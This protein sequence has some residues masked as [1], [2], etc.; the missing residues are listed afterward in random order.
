MRVIVLAMLALVWLAGAVRAGGLDE[1]RNG[2]AAFREGRY[3][4]AVELFTTAIVSGELDVEALAIAYN[5]R[6]VA[7]DQLGDYDRAV[8]DYQ[9]ALSLKPDDAMSRRNLRVVLVRRGVALANTGEYQRALTDLSKAIELGPDKAIA[10][11]RR[12]QVR[13][14][15]GDLEGAAADLAEARKLAPGDE[16]IA[17]AEERLAKLGEAAREA[18]VQLTTHSAP[19]PA[20]AGPAPVAEKPPAAAARP[21]VPATDGEQ[22]AAAEPPAASAAGTE[23][24]NAARKAGV[25]PAT[26]AAE[27]GRPYR[28]LADVNV[29]SGPGNRY[30]ARRIARKGTVVRVVGEKLGWK[31][32]IFEDG[33]R[34]FIYRKWLEPLDDAG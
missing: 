21:A 24:E 2:N 1:I 11:L 16:E 20:A 18:A 12:A 27:E 3:E 4:Q 31:E 34:G 23:T 5:N 8:A 29:R 25:E 10:W 33:G 14:E 15:S 30:A 13:M 17:R 6:G 32:V 7:Y 19:E 9:E 28:A 22:A 26:P